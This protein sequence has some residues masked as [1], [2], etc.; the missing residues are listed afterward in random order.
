MGFDLPGKLFHVMG[1]D[2]LESRVG[3]R[4]FQTALERMLRPITNP[5]HVPGARG[6][7]TNAVYLPFLTEAHRR[8]SRIPSKG[9]AQLEMNTWLAQESSWSQRGSRE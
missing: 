6:S 3:E 1:P 4:Q 5:C 8:Q 2:S 9:Q 7:S